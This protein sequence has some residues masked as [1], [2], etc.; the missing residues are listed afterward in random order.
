MADPK[1]SVLLNKV[2]VAKEKVER[3]ESERN[4][5][6][7]PILAVLGATGGGI[8]YVGMS[9]DGPTGIML[10]VTRVGSTRGCSW[11]DD[12]TFPYSIFTADDPIAAAK[13][14]VTKKKE[15]EEATKR[16]SKL[17]E[18]ERLHRELGV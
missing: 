13:E 6:L 7:E 1:I 16:A 9:V 10:E 8:E 11:S 2:S 15:A 12:Y 17:A 18:L 14:F 5:F 3:A 4:A